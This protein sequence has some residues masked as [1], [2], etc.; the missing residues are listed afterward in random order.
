[1]T[2]ITAIQLYIGMIAAGLCNG[3]GSAIGNYLAQ[4]HVI[5]NAKKL[6]EHIRG[7]KKW[8]YFKKLKN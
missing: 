5:E 4:H 2:E 6:K 1:M 3:I 8:T 7:R